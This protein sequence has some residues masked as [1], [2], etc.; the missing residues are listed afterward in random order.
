MRINLILLDELNEDDRVKKLSRENIELQAKISSLASELE[1]TRA[2][3][4]NQVH[5]AEKVTRLNSRIIDE[6]KAQFSSL[7]SEKTSLFNKVRMSF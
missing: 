1:E 3:K 2:N 6:Q 7:E 5:E 4:E